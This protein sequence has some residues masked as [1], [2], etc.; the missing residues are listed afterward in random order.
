MSIF[1]CLPEKV[2]ELP[3]RFYGMYRS[4]VITKEL[5]N[6]LEVVCW[7]V[8]FFGGVVVVVVA[9]CLNILNMASAL[10]TGEQFSLETSSFWLSFLCDSI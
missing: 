3:D 10:A 9:A 6:G 2:T 8:V 7:L 5:F 1:N 4:K